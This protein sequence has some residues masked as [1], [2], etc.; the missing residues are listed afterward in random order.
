LKKKYSNI[1]FFI[2]HI[3]NNFL[4]T[5]KRKRKFTPPQPKKR[6]MFEELFA[7]TFTT[8]L[9]LKRSIIIKIFSAVTAYCFFTIKTLR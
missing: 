7:T 5:K 8:I 1:N 4:Q 3:E 9:G 6:S 2:I